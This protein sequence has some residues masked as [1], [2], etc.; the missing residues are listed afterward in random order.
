MIAVAVS[1]SGLLQMLWLYYWARKSGFNFALRRP[2]FTQD[3]RS[4]GVL[5][6]PAIFGAGIYQ[7]SR[8][9]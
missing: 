8:F 7:I 4:L 2:R 6:L 5:I 1:I 9:Y 3:V